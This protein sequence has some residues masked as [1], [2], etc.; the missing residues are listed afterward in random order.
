ML[1]KNT[2]NPIWTRQTISDLNNFPSPHLRK[3]T[4]PGE[5]PFVD[6]ITVP[7]IEIENLILFRAHRSRL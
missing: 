7:H 2:G 3:A 4:Y 6:Q 5:F 1:G